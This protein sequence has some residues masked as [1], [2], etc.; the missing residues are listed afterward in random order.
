LALLDI[1]V[2]NYSHL[3]TDKNLEPVLVEVQPLLNDSDLHIAQLTMNLLTSVAKGHKSS[4]KVVQS[5]SFSQI[6]LLAR[7]PLLQ[8]AALNSMLEFFKS[9]VAAN[10]P[11]LGQKDLLKLLVDPVLSP[12]GASIH[13]QGRASI[14]KCVAALVVT[15][16]PAEA[17]NVV[18]QFASHLKPNDSSTAHQQTFSL[19]V[20]GEIGKHKDLS[21]INGLKNI[22]IESFNHNSE[23]VK[24]AAS[25]ALS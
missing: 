16:S 4:I 9:L 11:G 5:T 3:I 18:S 1:L 8:G 24:S 15:Q 7:S 25:Y 20:I 6:L 17:Q 19:L 2:K 13:K 14:A 10:L 23:E 12:S 22:I 21:K